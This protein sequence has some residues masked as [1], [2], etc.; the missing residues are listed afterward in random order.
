MDRQQRWKPLQDIWRPWRRL[1]PCR[2]VGQ[3]PS[4]PFTEK[5]I[6]DI[7][8]PVLMDCPEDRGVYHRIPVTI[9][10]AFGKPP[11]LYPAP[12]QMEALTLERKQ[13]RTHSLYAAALFHLKFEGVHSFIDG[14]GR[15]GGSLRNFSPM[16]NS[17][18]PVNVKFINRRACY[19]CSDA[20]SRDGDAAP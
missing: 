17:D 16:K 1:A 12:Q 5:V 10:G 9:F 13:S 18:P 3:E 7:H 2:A 15:T 11:Q 20:Y 14:S 4:A 8:S 6:R 19:G